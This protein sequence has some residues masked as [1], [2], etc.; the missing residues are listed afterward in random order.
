MPKI[1]NDSILWFKHRKGYLEFQ[2][3]GNSALLLFR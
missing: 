2:L 3:G 1:S